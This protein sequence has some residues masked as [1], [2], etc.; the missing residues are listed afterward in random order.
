ME[1]FAIIIQ[2]VGIVVLSVCQNK[3]YIKKRRQQKEQIV[4]ESKK[5]EKSTEFLVYQKL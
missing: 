3:W 1:N 4:K 5:R 2:I